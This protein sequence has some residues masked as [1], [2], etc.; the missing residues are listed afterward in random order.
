[1]FQKE[2]SADGKKKKK[3][4]LS[5]VEYLA[6]LL[7]RKAYSIEEVRR[8]MREKEYSVSESEEAVSS[9][10]RH[11]FLNDSSFA[12]GLANSLN[13][14]GYGRKRI[15]AKLREK[16][17]D[18]GIIRSTLSEMDN[19]ES[20]PLKT[21]FLSQEE[22]DTIEEVPDAEESAA[23]KALKGKW[24]SLK[25]EEDPRKRKEKALRFLAGR[26]FEPRICYKV[27]NRFLQEEESS[28]SFF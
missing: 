21:P 22:E 7:S 23:I 24:R 11:G 16:G 9:F 28:S 26:G 27:L 17:V 2:F 12:Q 1:M 13:S 25:Q 6:S 8:K 4:R 19:G 14:A 18:S 20:T 15:L 5:P 10:I 3:S